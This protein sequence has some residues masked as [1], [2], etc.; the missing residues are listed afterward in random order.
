MVNLEDNPNFL[1]R[2]LWTDESKFC[3]NGVVN[4]HNSHYW[5]DTNPHLTIESK[6]QFRW[7]INVWC[8]VI[9]NK[10]IGPYFFEENLN[11]TRYLNFLQNDILV[12]LED[13][14]LEMRQH[15][16]WQQDGA[17]AHNAKIVQQYLN[18]I[19]YNG[20]WIGTN[21]PVVKWPPR[22]LDFYLWSYLKNEVFREQQQFSS[23]EE[24][25]LKITEVCLNIP[26]NVIKRATNNEVKRRLELCFNTVGNIFN[27]CK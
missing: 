21:N 12:L 5:S 9:D 8:G 27:I 11:A 19:F 20:I 10:L 22:S 15:I 24:L 16:I 13:I 26:Q 6:S 17:P 3:N 14:L 1:S 7:N 25:K 2:I 18:T 4:H 23:K